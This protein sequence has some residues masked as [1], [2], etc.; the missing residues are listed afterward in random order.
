MRATQ[1]SLV[2]QPV[3]L[4]SSVPVDPKRVP[5]VLLIGHLANLEV[6]I[7]R[8]GGHTVALGTPLAPDLSPFSAHGAS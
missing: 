3:T 8:L 1:A 7:R 5:L 4:A 2:E 6:E